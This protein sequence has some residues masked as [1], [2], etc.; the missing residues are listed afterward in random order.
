[1][2]VER[3]TL[4]CFAASYAMALALEAVHLRRPR[5]VLRLFS[6]GFGAAGVLAHTLFL[7]VQRPPAAAPF[8]SLLFVAWVLAVFGVYGAVHHPKLAWG[9]FVLPLVLGLVV[10]AATL[11][12][13]EAASGETFFGLFGGEGFL[14]RLHGLL[15]ILAAVGVCVGCVASVMYLFQARRLKA[16]TLPGKGLKLYSLE[17]L[18]AMNRRAV[19]LAFPLMTSGVLVG[20]LL[21]MQQPD[22]LDGWTDPR[23]VSTGV[24]WLV[25]MLLL[26]LRYGY[27]L[28]GSR[29]A[30][31]TI[32][33]FALLV[34]TLVSSHAVV[35]GGGP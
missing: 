28:R 24:L 30:V 22:Q 18:E 23:I 15:L 8:G 16:K 26:Y 29:L 1:M 10:L 14:G 34:V 6:T 27:H 20:V 35:Q 17:R 13:P 21:L 5:A 31:L 3:I 11:G 19:N 9:V 33:A 2:P 25:F 4:F 12:R 7:L 32:I